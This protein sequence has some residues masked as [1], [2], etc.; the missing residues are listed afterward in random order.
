MLAGANTD[1]DDLVNL[2]RN[3]KLKDRRTDEKHAIEL[4][5][6][7]PQLSDKTF[8]RYNMTPLMAGI[9][10][11]HTIVHTKLFELLLHSTTNINAQN[12]EGKSV[13]HF[14]SY[15]AKSESK[16]LKYLEKLL[17]D[18]KD[19][20][21]VNLPTLNNE[22]P[23]YMAVIAGNVQALQ[24]L[25]LAGANVNIA[26]NQGQSPLHV[27]CIRG[28]EVSISILLDAGAKVNAA[29]ASGRTPIHYLAQCQAVDEEIKQRILFKLL[30]HGAKAA[31]MCHQRQL[32]EQGA[33]Q[34]GNKTLAD[35]L[36][37]NR[38]PSLFNICSRHICNNLSV[39]TSK[40][41]AFLEQT[42]KQQQK[43]T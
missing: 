16:R 11:K 9:Y 1:T 29:D 41:P 22:T 26:N 7:K 39:Y 14:L 25:V 13:L 12:S 37:A 38:V 33:I 18:K 6:R 42:I 36:Q 10:R 2:M 5:H 24:L 19:S 23:V 27:A 17:K 28:D 3:L 4:L 20:I 40:I 15:Y 21:D 34:F 32:A 8:T 30:E 43:C 31:L 35:Y